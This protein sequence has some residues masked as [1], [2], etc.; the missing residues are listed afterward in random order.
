[1]PRRTYSRERPRPF[2]LHGRGWT[3]RMYQLLAYDRRNGF[4]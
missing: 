2:A 4:R 1:M 3:E